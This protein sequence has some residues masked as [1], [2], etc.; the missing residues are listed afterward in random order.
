MFSA[1]LSRWGLSNPVASAYEL[2][3]FSVVLDWALPVGQW[4]SALDADNGYTFKGGSV[5]HVS[6]AKNVGFEVPA[7]HYSPPARV[8]I[9]A[10][11]SMMAVA[12]GFRFTRS[13][14][15]SSPFPWYP[16][17]RE[18]TL[19]SLKQA[20]NGLAMLTNAFLSR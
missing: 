5:S 11:S 12:E 17:W 19:P 16:S 8:Y 20:A 3:P 9:G 6:L 10:E 2:L 14:Y 15:G 13:T 18:L 7:T 4:L 1:F